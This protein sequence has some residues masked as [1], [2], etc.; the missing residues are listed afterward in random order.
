MSIVD[1]ALEVAGMS[2]DEVAALD[3][4]LPGFSRLAAKAKQAEPIITQMK[5]HID[6]LMPL[7]IKMWP[8]LQ[9]A[10]PDIVASTP[11]VEM[12]IDFAMSKNAGK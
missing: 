9:A 2:S 10:W 11:T 4:E 8:I 12:L 1:F 5:P 6:A 7:A 3:Y